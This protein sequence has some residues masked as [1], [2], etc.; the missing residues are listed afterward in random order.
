MGRSWGAGGGE[1]GVLRGGQPRSDFLRG[2]RSAELPPRAR[3]SRP[4]PRLR[5]PG[6]DHGESPA[7][8]AVA[9]PPGP[10]RVAG[11]RGRASGTRG[12]FRGRRGPGAFNL[13]LSLP[14][15]WTRWLALALALVAVAWVRA[16]VGETRRGPR[17]GAGRALHPGDALPGGT[18]SFGAW[19]GGRSGQECYYE[20]STSKSGREV[21][22]R[23]GSPTEANMEGEWGGGRGRAGWFGTGAEFKKA[24]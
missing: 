10:P 13:A 11:R 4:A 15:M 19:G 8:R 3:C 7:R 9:G 16:E 18:G 17:S 6:R 24:P 1:G 2:W 5:R 20:T 22:A 23:S 21:W 14:Q 12:S